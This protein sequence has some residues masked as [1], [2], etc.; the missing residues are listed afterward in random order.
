[1]SL[2]LITSSKLMIQL[3]RLKKL[4]FYCKEARNVTYEKTSYFQQQCADIT[5]NETHD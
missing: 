4:H 5:K 3:K 2:K 1:M